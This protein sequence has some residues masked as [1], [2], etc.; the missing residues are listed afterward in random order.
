MEKGKKKKKVEKDEETLTPK[1]KTAAKKTTVK[2]TAKKPSSEPISVEV[3]E[4]EKEK[5]VKKAVAEKIAPADPVKTA[6]K[7][8][9]PKVNSVPTVKKSS[10]EDSLEKSEESNVES[11][12]FYPPQMNEKEKKT[13]ESKQTARSAQEINESVIEDRYYD[14]R[15]VL[16]ARDPYWCYAYWDLAPQSVEEKRKELKSEW[17]AATLAL[18]VY[19][20]TDVNFN[21]A[22]AHK[23]QDV[24]VTGEAGNWYINVWAPGRSYLVEIG[25]KTEDGHFVAIARSNAILTPIDRPSDITD[26]EWIEVGEDFEEIFKASGGGQKHH[27]SGSEGLGRTLNEHLGSEQVSSFSSPTGGYGPKVKGFWMVV[28]TELILYGATEKDASVTVQERAVKLNPDGSFSLRFHLPD[29]RMELPVTAVSKD[30]TDTITV[31]IT[32]ERKSE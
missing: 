24:T 25:F 8:V 21:G 18:R 16:M 3:P 26:E 17:G 2:K 9:I 5:T 28:D 19:D 27:L 29:T 23:Y 32:V 31:K 12:K 22:N 15:I 13:F 6:P 30:G 4:I 11:A 7:K 20:V 1:K 14:N 10:L